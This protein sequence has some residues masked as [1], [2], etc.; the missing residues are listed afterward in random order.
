[1]PTYPG[2]MSDSQLTLAE[3]YTLGELLNSNS[4]CQI[5]CTGGGETQIPV[6]LKSSQC[7]SDR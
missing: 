1:M 5:D 2:Y 7:N 4:H 3:H 6:F